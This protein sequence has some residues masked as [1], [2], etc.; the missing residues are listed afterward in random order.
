[1][2][3]RKSLL[4]LALDVMV[5]VLGVGYAVVSSVNLTVS[6]TAE[7]ETKDLDVVISA[8]NPSDN[9]TDTY[10]TVKNPA[11]KTATITVKNM[12]GTADTRTVTYTVKNNEEDLAAKVYVK[13]PASDIVV[14]KSDYFNVVTSVDGVGNA[15]TIPAGGTDTFTV[16]VT[17]KKVPIETSDSSTDITITLTADPVQGS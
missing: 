13:T 12:T 14:G 8:A 5:L 9:T 15:I 3:N 10:G 7:T 4:G 1:M 6:G 17:L 16:T 2:K 11:D